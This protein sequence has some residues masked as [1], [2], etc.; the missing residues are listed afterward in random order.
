MPRTDPKR[1]TK[2]ESESERTTRDLTANE[3]ALKNELERLG[4]V[5]RSIKPVALANCK[6]L[7]LSSNVK[8]RL[9]RNASEAEKLAA[10]HAALLDAI[11]D[12]PT[13][14][15][16]HIG[17]AVLAANN[18]EGLLVQQR[19]EILAGYGVSDKIFKQ[20]RPQVVRALVHYL[21]STTPDPSTDVYTYSECVDILLT[22][23]CSANTLGA[24]FAASA[25]I[26]QMNYDLDREGRQKRY[27]RM[28]RVVIEALVAANSALILD[29]F[30]CT[31]GHIPTMTT[32]FPRDLLAGLDEALRHLHEALPV[33]EKQRALLCENFFNGV[34]SVNSARRACAG[35]N[36]RWRHWT[37]KEMPWLF[38]HSTNYREPVL[39][40]QLTSLSERIPA[41]IVV[42]LRVP[43]PAPSPPDILERIVGDYYGVD[44]AFRFG[45]ESLNNRV[46][47]FSIWPSDGDE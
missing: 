41:C 12:L 27:R 36:D 13:Q 19:R 34:S 4:R 40:R 15:D 7:C 8:A 21:A 47:N 45:G 32:Y 5:A 37:E 30:E 20:R 24:C 9:G 2:G 28:P 6:E 25:F 23:A 38:S 39:I 18:Y 35:I 26:L 22:L 29:G 42:P 11:A 33:V 3:R 10:A 14:Q 17:E 43:Y 31:S 16:R 46:A 44:G 1:P